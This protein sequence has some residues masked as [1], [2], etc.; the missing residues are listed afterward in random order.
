[1]RCE[2]D[3]RAVRLEESCHFDMSPVRLKLLEYPKRMHDKTVLFQ[4]LFILV[5]ILFLP[6]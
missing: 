1:M 3:Y 2:F 6:V 5:F 4:F